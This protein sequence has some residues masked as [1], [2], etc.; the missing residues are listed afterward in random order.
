MYEP[1]EGREQMKSTWKI[2]VGLVAGLAFTAPAWAAELPEGWSEPTVAHDG[3]RVMRAEGHEVQSRFHYQPPGKH[4]QEM[5]AEGMQMSMIIRQDLEVVWTI[6]PGGTSYME[7]GLGETEEDRRAGPA[8]EGIVEYRKIGTEVVN[9]WP[10]THY[11][12]VTNEDG[13]EAEGDVWVTEHWIPV[14]MEIVMRNDPSNRVVMEVRDLQVRPQNPALFELPPG[15]TKLSGF[16][17]FGFGGDGGDGAGFSF[18]GELAGEAADTARD[19]A[20]EETREGVRDAV[21][22]G[23]RGLFRR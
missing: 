7:M 18:P 9:G 17:G 19:T 6:L 3:I 4:R 8:P 15:A 5:Q 10:T 11:H 1:R 16:G 2:A 21:R 23:V 14:R 12:I 22:E 20:R 13:E